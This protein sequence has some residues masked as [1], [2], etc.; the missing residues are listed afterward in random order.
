MRILIVV[1]FALDEQG[2]QLRREQLSGL[3]FGEGVE[4]DFVPIVAGPSFDDSYHDWL[5][6]DFSIFHTA[7][8]AER[9]GYDAVCVDTV[10]DNGVVALR[11]VLRIPVIGP[12]RASY[13]SALTLADTFSILTV[14]EPWVN[15][16]KK[17]LK[18]SGVA[19]KCKS[20][21]STQGYMP[22][23]SNLLGGKTEEVAAQLIELGKVDPRARC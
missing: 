11:S 4:F 18:E 7:M 5:L 12:G 19:D 14:W 21:L 1:P 3:D 10:G 22:D 6:G 23:L 2:V 15:S 9:D 16:Y 17:T 13:M 8:H 20:I